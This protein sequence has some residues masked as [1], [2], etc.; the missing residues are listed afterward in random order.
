MATFLF[1]NLNR[2]PLIDRVVALCHERSVDV[3]VLAESTISDTALLQSLNRGQVS[4]Y[5]LPF[6]LS[7]RLQFYVRFPPHS[8]RPVSD[9]GGIAIRHLVPPIGVDMLLVA[10]HLPSKLHMRERDQALH[11]V[12]VAEAIQ[13]AEGHIGH[14]RTL[15]IGDLN[16]NPF[17]D[18][19]TGAS[20]LHAVM[21]KTIAGRGGRIVQGK[22]WEFF[23]NPMWSRMG[24]GSQGPPGT[25]YYNDSGYVSYFWH[26][27]DQ[28]LMRP[29]LLEY[30]RDDQLQVV[31]TVEGESLLTP[32]GI[33]ETSGSDHLPVAATFRIEQGG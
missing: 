19:M 21:D 27:F 9:E 10:L 24:D 13:E 12:R 3:L 16:M 1:W 17:E 31:T 20:A 32:N 8:F 33:P 28:V 30:F 18:G 14:N 15:V 2:K 23:Y 26:T 29:A 22:R 5:R 6:N 4:K 25:Y 7:T 11:A